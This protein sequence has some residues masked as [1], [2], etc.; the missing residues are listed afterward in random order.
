VDTAA[1]DVIRRHLEPGEQL[2]WAGRPP[3]GVRARLV[4]LWFVPM[5]LLSL[6][7]IALVLAIGQPLA[8]SGVG[9][10]GITVVF[11]AVDRFILAPRRRARTWY[12]L[13]SERVVVIAT[14][15]RTRRTTTAI[16]ARIGAVDFIERPDGTGV[17]AF[18]RLSPSWL[19]AGRE[20]WTA[21]PRDHVVL[22]LPAPA[23]LVFELVRDTQRANHQFLTPSGDA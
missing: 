9:L 6:F 12:G 8:L 23:S 3:Q 20:L 13:T 18:D 15:G 16:L 14:R 22:D 19:W 7:G 17:L 5:L 1:E 4:D 10:Y 11:L 2:I 21:K